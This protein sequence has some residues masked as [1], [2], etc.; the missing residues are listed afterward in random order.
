M[1]IVFKKLCEALIADTI[2]YDGLIVCLLAGLAAWFAD[3]AVRTFGTQP[4]S[5]TVLAAAT[6]G[7]AALAFLVCQNDWK[8]AGL[9][10]AVAAVYWAGRKLGVGDPG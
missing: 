10:A 1:G 7:L 4:V 9:L 8:A 3:Y 5:S 2:G 6:T